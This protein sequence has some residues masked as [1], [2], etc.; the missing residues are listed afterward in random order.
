MRYPLDPSLRA[1]SA[2][3]LPARP[4]LLA[5]AGRL[6]PL[7]IRCRSDARVTVQRVALPGGCGIHVIRPRNLP[8]ADVLL[9]LHGG[10]F[11]FPASGAHFALAKE[12]ALRMPCTVLC[13]DYRLQPHPIPAQDSLAAYRWMLDTLH[14]ARFFVCGDSAGGALA[15][16]VCLMAR[17]AGLPLPRGS[18]LVYPVLDRRMTTPS[19][20]AYPDTS[21]WNTKLNRMMWKTY[22]GN[23]APQPIEYASPLEAPTFAHFP[24]TYIEVAQYDCLHD[25]GVQL[26]QR[27]L[28]EHIP[29]VLHDIPAACH[30]FETALHS[31][32]TRACME[33]RI[34][35]LHSLPAE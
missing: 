32:I 19:M 22:L 34:R 16:A 29:S 21:V 5:A 20:H 7:F 6:M 11:L 8:T 14:P 12:Y 17:D 13:V 33:H 25:E 1:L 26:H 28:A 15:A 9:Y 23:T 27:L 4:R 30:G 24:S 10:G 3:S 2:L 35:W 31:P 18:L